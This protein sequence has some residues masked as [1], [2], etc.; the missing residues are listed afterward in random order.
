MIWKYLFG[1]WDH[2]ESLLGA[3]LKRRRGEPTKN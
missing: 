1:K 3:I 2:S